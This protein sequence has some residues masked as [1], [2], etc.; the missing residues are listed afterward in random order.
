[1][2]D[3]SSSI[4]LDR[5][6][7]TESSMKCDIDLDPV[8]CDLDD[9]ACCD[10]D[11]DLVSFNFLDPFFRDR[12]WSEVCDPEFDKINVEL[13][14][15][16]NISII[17]CDI[18]QKYKLLL[19]LDPLNVT[20][21]INLFSGFYKIKYLRAICN[22]IWSVNSLIHI[23]SITFPILELS[24]TSWSSWWRWSAEKNQYIFCELFIIETKAWCS[25]NLAIQPL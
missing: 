17:F 10:I 16:Y 18:K 2:C 14:D 9:P 20:F 11:P 25:Q 12:D 22:P 13:S 8:C 15:P 3:L 24:K 1:M 23:F 4:S 6:P 7:D 5:D 19:T 21:V